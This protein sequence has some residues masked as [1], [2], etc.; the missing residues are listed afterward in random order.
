MSYAE[1]LRQVDIFCDL[2]DE[3]LNRLAGICYQEARRYEPENSCCGGLVRR[4]VSG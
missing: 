2:A 1:S 4:E 3:R